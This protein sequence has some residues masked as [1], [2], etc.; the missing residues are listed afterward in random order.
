MN[1]RF[2]ISKYCSFHDIDQEFIVALH[3]EGLIEVTTTEQGMFIEDTQ[4]TDLEVYTRW[5]REFGINAEGMDVARNL[6]EKIRA[7]QEE[8][9]QLKNRLN[10]YEAWE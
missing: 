10:M 5:H 1:T 4:L 8:I 2:E 9:L 7:L 6:L 3:Q